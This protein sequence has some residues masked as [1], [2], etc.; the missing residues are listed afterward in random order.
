MRTAG[1]DEQLIRRAEDSTL[2]FEVRRADALLRE[3][4]IDEALAVLAAIDEA[5]TDPARKDWARREI[6][7][8]QDSEANGAFNATFNDAVQLINTGKTTEGMVLLEA[9]VDQAPSPGQAAAARELLDRTR[10][11]TIYRAQADEAAALA[12]SGEI[13]AA[14]EILEPL[15][16][17]APDSNQAAEISRFLD[18]LHG[19]RDFQKHYNEAVDLVNG[20]N[21]V[22]AIAVLQPLAGAA[23]TPQLA[24]MASA[25]L[26]ELK[27]M[28]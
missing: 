3:N 10:A 15:L 16:A 11:Y 21:F 20:G 17:E 8:L 27:E 22:A 5:T 23:P 24:A 25:L 18:Q 6:R 19:Y 4:R 9:L 13:E 7:R 14:I 28:R 1:V 12:S 26:E 2:D